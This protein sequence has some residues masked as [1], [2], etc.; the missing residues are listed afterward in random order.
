MA[1][2]EDFSDAFLKSVRISNVLNQENNQEGGEE[3][4]KQENKEKMQ[5]F[6]EK[7]NRCDNYI[8]VFI[9]FLIQS[10]ISF[11]FFYAYYIL[12]FAYK[13][14][15]LYFIVIVG[16][17]MILIIFSGFIIFF[18]STRFNSKY[19][20]CSNYAFF[21]LIN[22]YKIYFEVITYLIIVH[23]DDV[24]Q[25]DFPQF[26]ARAF[27]KISIFFL[28]LMLIVYYLFKKEK[29]SFKFLILLLFSLISLVACF[30]LLFFT[31]KSEYNNK[32]IYEYLIYMSYEILMV[33]YS[34]FMEYKFHG[35]LESFGMK[36]DWRINRID[37]F[38]YLIILIPSI[39]FFLK[40][41]RK[42]CCCNKKKKILVY[43]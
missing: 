30:L 28:Y 20:K 7:E 5:N 18:G 31:H 11:G 36:I 35:I 26:E 38:R 33:L 41:C 27:W 2:V 23:D 40:Y 15:N 10:A 17:L 34:F 16:M 19:K 42:K 25:L 3:L 24:D 12:D 37:F 43:E 9:I 22:I 14:D 4:I 13:N 39:W 21:I 1:E 29:T 32:R 6:L 8:Y